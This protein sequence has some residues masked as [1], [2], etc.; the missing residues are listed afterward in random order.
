MGGFKKGK[1]YTTDAKVNSLE[2]EMIVFVIEY[3]FLEGRPNISNSFVSV[4][5]R[6]LIY[7]TSSFNE[8]VADGRGFLT[9]YVL[10]ILTKFSQRKLSCIQLCIQ[11]M[12]HTV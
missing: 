3:F 4:R 1:I 5:K 7:S 8:S 6:V 2:D 11:I 12:Q 9:F 10:K